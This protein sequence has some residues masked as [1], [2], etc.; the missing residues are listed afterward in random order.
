[1][2]GRLTQGREAVEQDAIAW[3]LRL[4]APD[5]T[6]ADW[7]DLQAWLDAAPEHREAL[8]R[9]EQLSAELTQSAPQLLAALGPRP[10]PAPR[11]ERAAQRRPQMRA[12]LWKAVGGLAAAAAA[13][14]VFVAVRP[15]APAPAQVYQTA[16]GE[17]RVLDLADGSKIHLNSASRIT[18]RFEAKGRHVELAEGQAAFD[19]AHDSSRPFLI[20]AGDR[21]IRVV[22]TEFDVL[23]HEG[24]LRVTV[25]R[26]RVAV[27]SPDGRTGMQ[28]VMLGVGDQLDHLPGSRD[29]VLRRVDPDAALAW[30]QGDLVYRDQPLSEVVGDLNRYFVTP[31]RVVGPA[32][33]LRFSG[34]LRIDTQ[35]TVVRRLQGFLPLDA[36]RG[37]DGVILRARGAAG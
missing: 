6:E 18:V 17:S 31:V 33:S 1:M 11:R 29:W 21:D 37:P 34:V 14:V 26:G 30:R 10:G 27:Q 4:D 16:K 15:E 36:E 25:R 20:A 9:V 8:D 3:L 22:G 2:N 19:V 12:R 5:A 35:E 13:L 7:L 28:P 23:R 24:R 32:S